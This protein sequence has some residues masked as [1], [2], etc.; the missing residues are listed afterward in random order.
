LH[1]PDP[2]LLAAVFE[3]SLP[4]QFGRQGQPAGRYARK[5][6]TDSGGLA[7]SLRRRGTIVCS[8][9]P[10]RAAARVRNSLRSY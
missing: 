5:P 3:A 6:K 7:R 1:P 8:S 4:R 2:P 10:R 9:V